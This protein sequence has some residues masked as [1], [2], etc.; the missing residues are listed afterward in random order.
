MSKTPPLLPEETLQRVLRVARVDGMSVLLIAGFLALA[1]AAAG[2]YMGALIGLVIAAAGAIEL[3]GDGLLRNGF[4][5]GMKWLIG[6]QLY[7]MAVVLGYCAMRLTHV[8]LP[9]I[10]DTLKPMIEMSAQ[11]WK[12]ATDDYLLMVYRLSFRLLALLTFLYQ[13]GMAF[14]YFR[15][16][17]AVAQALAAAE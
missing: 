13:G 7:L 16:R 11:Q 14:Y 4:P 9:P 2:D 6:S 5:L 12:M 1:S 3:H 10:P 17:A 15:R 8:A